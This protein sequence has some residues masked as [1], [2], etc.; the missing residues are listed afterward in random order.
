LSLD[1]KPFD[2]HTGDQGGDTADNLEPIETDVVENQEPAED[3]PGA[4]VDPVTGVYRLKPRVPENEDANDNQYAFANP[5]PN[6]AQSAEH[7]TNPNHEPQSEYASEFTDY[8]K[9]SEHE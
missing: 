4:E 7:E 5:N 6:L 9:R 8:F 1:L 2:L 3:K